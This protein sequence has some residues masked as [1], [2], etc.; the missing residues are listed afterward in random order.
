MTELR[1]ALRL[2]HNS[3]SN[4]GPVLPLSWGRGFE[5]ERGASLQTCAA[6]SGTILKAAKEPKRPPSPF[7]RYLVVAGTRAEYNNFVR[8][9]P[10]Q[11]CRINSSVV[12]V[13]ALFLCNSARAAQTQGY[14]DQL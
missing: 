14:A 12:M 6:I 1:Q 2:Q 10:S 9:G 7:I 5:L 13:C 8:V 4:P 11:L 3:K